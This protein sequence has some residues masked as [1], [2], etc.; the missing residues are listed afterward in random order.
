MHEITGVWRAI[1]FT[2]TSMLRVSKRHMSA[3]HQEVLETSRYSNAH[4]FRISLCITYVF[5]VN[6][7]TTVMG[8]VFEYCMRPSI[9]ALYCKPMLDCTRLDCYLHMALCLRYLPTLYI[10]T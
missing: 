7:R 10:R 8:L 1:N 2:G 3:R 5:M 4:F 6:D 9:S